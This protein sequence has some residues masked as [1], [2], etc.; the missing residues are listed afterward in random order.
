MG[1]TRRSNLEMLRL[2]AMFM[3]VGHHLALYGVEIY[4]K[5][6]LTVNKVLWETLFLMQGKVG[7]V[8]FL[9]ISFYFLAES[10][11]NLFNSF[12]KAWILERTLLF[13]SIVLSLLCLSFGLIAIPDRFT[14]RARI[15][16]Q[17]FTPVLSNTWWF[18]TSYIGFL[19]M[20][21]FILKG[22]TALT[23]RWHFV[24]CVIVL[25]VG[26]GTQLPIFNASAQLS[27]GLFC[28]EFIILFVL[29]AYMRWYTDI[30]HET[31]LAPICLVLGYGGSVFHSVTGYH[32]L[33]GTY[34][35]AILLE[36]LGWFILFFNFSFSSKTVNFLASHVFA[37]YLITEFPGLRMPLW[38]F[39]MYFI[40][41]LSTTV[42]APVAAALSIFVIGLV[43]IVL[44][45]V[46]NR[47]F[48]VTV[49]RNPG[50]WFKSL[51][52]SLNRLVSWGIVPD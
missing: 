14:Q 44:D 6:E 13:W 5:P 32:E 48:S 26:L 12:R 38:R 25:C 29:I 51:W 23:Q 46:R 17:V 36:A 9:G 28:T 42:W 24:L 19:L 52:A 22:L 41:P 7:V 35:L 37:V 50:S 16:I 4:K 2:V 10:H 33:T 34:N 11:L 27:E 18:A 49:D 1:K 31:Y 20:F 3:I 47:I 21:P 8:L 30:F 43:C 39:V 40:R 15:V 45:V